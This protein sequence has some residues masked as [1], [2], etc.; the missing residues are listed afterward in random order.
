MKTRS[1]PEIYPL[2]YH[3]I[4][5]DSDRDWILS[6]MAAIPEERKSEVAREYERLFLGGIPGNRKEANTYLHNEAVK[7]RDG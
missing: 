7:Y 5:K 1:N 6:R 2:F 4:G 3:Q